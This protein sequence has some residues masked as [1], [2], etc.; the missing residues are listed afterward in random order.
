MSKPLKVVSLSLL[1]ASVAVAEPV[2]KY[3]DE[4]GVTHYVNSESSVPERFRQSS[5]TAAKLPAISRVQVLP[6]NLDPRQRAY[7]GGVQK[8][9][10]GVAA[11]GGDKQK[12]ASPKIH[13]SS[14]G[15]RVEV[16]VTSWCGYCRQLEKFLRDKRVSFTKTD[17]E[18]S[19][20]NLRRYEAL[21]GGGVPL[22]KVGTRVVAG[23]Q[24]DE[25]LRLLGH[26]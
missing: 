5:V 22:T 3:V 11:F 25:I 8:G 26:R 2:Y 14:A 4:S 1:L 9:K 24:P 13:G 21:G 18:A 12:G 10:W 20:Q 6:Q 19:A 17:I 23:Y 16:F 7:R 15:K